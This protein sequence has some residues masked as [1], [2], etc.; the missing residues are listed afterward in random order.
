M[1]KVEGTNDGFSPA[2]SAKMKFGAHFY[3]LMGNEYNTFYQDQPN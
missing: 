3:T 1:L 2:S